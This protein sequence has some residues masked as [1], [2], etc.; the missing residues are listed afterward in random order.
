MSFRSDNVPDAWIPQLTKISHEVVKNARLLLFLLIGF[1]PVVSYAQAAPSLK[2]GIL[3]AEAKQMIAASGLDESA[4]SV[5]VVPLPPIVLLGPVVQG[6]GLNVERPFNPASVMKLVTT[7]A[8]LGILGPNYRHQTRIATTGQLQGGVL[9]GDLYFQGGG[10]PKLVVEDLEEIARRLR[11]MGIDR[12]EGKLIVDGTRFDEPETDPGQFDQRPYSTY[13]VGPHAAMVNFKSVRISVWPE[14]GR[15][16]RVMTQPSLSASDLT[17]RVQLVE[18]SCL[19]SRVSAQMDR[20]G[21]VLVSGQLGKRCDGVDFYVS[22]FDHARFAFNAFRAAWES[23][24]G[25]IKVDLVSGA[26]PSHARTLVQW[27]SPRPLI[28]LVSDINKMS[29]NPMTRQLFLNLSAKEG[30]AATRDR[31]RKIVR[32]Y[33]ASRGMDFPELVIDN[34]SGLSRA[35]RI[36][37]V[38]LARLL[39]DALLGSDAEAWVNTL[40]MMGI[41]GTVRHRM[42]NS[43]LEGRAWLKTGTLNDVRALAGYVRSAEGR[44]VVFVAMVNHPEA[45]RSKIAMDGLLKWAYTSH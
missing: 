1:H 44:W 41:E 18:G 35:E 40:P 8:A 4:W 7:R 34:G 19:R 15:K 26:T 16:V 3:P 10:D 23:V 5:A 45:N 28:D 11:A 36:S 17:T 13:N 14:M 38:S 22:L 31:S 25:E 9:K 33:L 6:V 2:I 30:Q 37:A 24:G 27:E 20:S 29:N 32:E 42:R 12:I 43:V 21:K 39:A